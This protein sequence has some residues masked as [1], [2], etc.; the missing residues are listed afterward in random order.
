MNE[1]FLREMSLRNPMNSSI[2]IFLISFVTK[3]ALRSRFSWR[4]TE[5]Q[6]GSCIM[7]FRIFFLFL[8]SLQMRIGSSRMFY[9]CT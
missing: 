2:L 1:S 8:S 4:D 7:E 9:S 3:L 6:W 5:D